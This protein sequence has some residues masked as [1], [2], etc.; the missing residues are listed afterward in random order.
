[1]EQRIERNSATDQNSA[2]WLSNLV[3]DGLGKV[4]LVDRTM[5]FFKCIPI[6]VEKE[7]SLKRYS[8]NVDVHD[9]NFRERA[10]VLIHTFLRSFLTSSLAR[11]QQTKN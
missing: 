8:V 2:S 10:P 1:M 7:A 9:K 3:K 5:V 4:E 11:L 6:H